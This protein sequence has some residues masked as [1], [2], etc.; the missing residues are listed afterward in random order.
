MNH[1][2]YEEISIGLKES[3]SVTITEEMQDSF[4][5]ITGDVN[6]L[7]ADTKYAAE[8]GHKD[9]VVFGMLSAS[10]LSTLAGVYIPGERSL[11]QSVEIKFRKPVYVGD[12]L[13][14]EGTVSDKSDAVRCITVK[15]SMT[16]QD[17]VKVSRGEMQIGVD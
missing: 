10:L 17:G 7:H 13:T 8:K 6:P 4:R 3:F 16:N 9:K 12:T 14:I 2:Q 11:I 5:K 1:F 15:Y